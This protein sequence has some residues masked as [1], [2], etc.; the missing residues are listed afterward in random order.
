MAG[1]DY[2][3]L[4]KD[5]VARVGGESNII[6]VV[7][8]ATR[9]RFTLKS[10]ESVSKTAVEALPGVITVV[11]K[12]GQFQVVIGN[13][14]P[15]V[16]AA[17]PATLTA[18]DKV[19]AESA[20]AVSGKASGQ[21]L[22][23][24]AI[25]VVSSIFA[26][27][28]GVMC[29]SGILKGLLVILSTTGIL[30]TSTTTY[31][32]LFAAADAF[33]AFLPIILAVTAARKFGAN[34]YAAMT[35]AGALIYTN[36]V[37]V[38]WLVDGKSTPMTMLAYMRSGAAIDFLNIP[39]QLQVYTSSVV[40]VILAVWLQSHLEKFSNR[41]IHEAVRNFLTPLISL[42]VM[43][44]LTLLTVGPLG[45]WLSTL[46]ANMMTNAYNL[47]PVLVGMLM[48]GLWQVL[49]IFGIHWSVT[50]LFINNI[51]TLGYDFLKAGAFPAVLAQAG[52]TIGVL[53]RVRDP[54]TKAIAASA[55][56]AA[57]FGITEPAVYGVTLPRKRAF[58]IALISGAIGGGV[59]GLAGVR[60][61]ATGAPGVL[62]LPIG[63]DPSNPGNFLW[64]LAGTG[65]SFL[66][67]GIGTYFFGL[68]PAD[69]AK[70]AAAAKASAEHHAH[71]TTV[72]TGAADTAGNPGEVE[73]ISP[74]KGAV[75]PLAEV[76]D[77][78]FSSGSMG[79]GFGIIPEA[80]EVQ[81]P[82]SGQVVVSMGHAFGIRSS[83]GVE[84][85][86]HVGIDTVTLSGAPF[87][88]VVPVGTEI[89]AG[90]L[91]AVADLDAIEAAGLDTT[92]VVVVTNSAEFE[93][94]DVVASGPVDA[95]DVAV[96][97]QR[98]SA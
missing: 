80:G 92:T 82:I 62:T 75:I 93:A 47:S 2:G 84:I 56:V 25:D 58:V 88:K 89:K 76:N 14:V 32:V 77:R 17:L 31:Q 27:I 60:V 15:R 12:G 6:A 24:R 59:I 29:A 79:R 98:S 70:D 11:E 16:F 30:A 83:Q 45:T 1:I 19:A 42:V 44:P 20:K 53:L 71:V 35:I 68:S 46:M 91:L 28:L 18:D 39:L 64:L 13:N 5:I 57:V 65:L 81:S 72:P 40:P 41:F 69:V 22:L 55:A 3:I 49:V 95:G 10:T 21:N 4:A 34:P 61:F 38:N 66:L 67:A 74:M 87:S 48:G 94:V 85:L 7:H 37:S 78:V 8:C 97:T 51:A 43:V 33:F 54:K 86:V 23:A 50:P 26:P 90:D 52:A 9:L 63:I 73:I 36:L 96:L